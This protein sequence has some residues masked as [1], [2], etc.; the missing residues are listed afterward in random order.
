M[1]SRPED[2]ARAVSGL[3]EALEVLVEA[4]ALDRGDLPADN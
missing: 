4:G 2:L 1:I 3:A